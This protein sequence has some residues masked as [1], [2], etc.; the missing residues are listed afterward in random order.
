MGT[1]CLSG[2]KPLVIA[3]NPNVVV[4]LLCI[5]CY[6]ALIKKKFLYPF[7]KHEHFSR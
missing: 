2:T 5:P 7:T 3:N 4:L 6:T 1:K